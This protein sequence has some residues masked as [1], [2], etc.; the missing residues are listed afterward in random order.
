MELPSGEIQD[1]K[2]IINIQKKI[3]TIMA[4]VKK[5]SRRELLKKFNII[6]LVSE[7]LLSLL[8]FVVDKMQKF[9]MCLDRV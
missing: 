9:Q 6:P 7:F 3:I 5:V 4:G 1:S 2:S 8:S